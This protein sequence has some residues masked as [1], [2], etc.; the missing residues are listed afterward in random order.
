MI[1]EQW[2]RLLLE[3]TI[4]QENV[5]VP[6]DFGSRLLANALDYAI[7]MGEAIADYKPDIVLLHVISEIPI[8]PM[9]ENTMKS[10]SSRQIMTALKVKDSQRSPFVHN[11]RGM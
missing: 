4:I 11:N 8:Y 10:K 2:L 9:F 6:Y 3:A 5:I 1:R 7:M